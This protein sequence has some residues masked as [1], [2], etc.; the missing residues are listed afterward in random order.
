MA[1]KPNSPSPKRVCTESAG[2][3]PPYTCQPPDTLQPMYLIVPPPGMVQAHIAPENGSI[4]AAP[5]L[6]G[7]ISAASAPNQ[8]TDHFAPPN[9]T[10]PERNRRHRLWLQQELGLQTIWDHSS[11][12]P[13][14]VEHDNEG[15]L[16]RVMVLNSDTHPPIAVATCN[17]PQEVWNQMGQ[18]HQVRVQYS[19]TGFPTN[20]W[21]PWWAGAPRPDPDESPVPDPDYWSCCGPYASDPPW[22]ES[23]RLSDVALPA[24][25]HTAGSAP[26][27]EAD[28]SPLEAEAAPSAEGGDT[29]V[30]APPVE[31]L[32][33]YFSDNEWDGLMTG[34]LPDTGV[35][36]EILHDMGGTSASSAG[37]SAESAP[38]ENPQ[39]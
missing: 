5:E 30:S 37:P 39:R 25:V 22:A 11:G 23:P 31:G 36:H 14:F 16:A 28:T 12:H 2:S 33:K 34:T 32:R 15:N 27:V 38:L 19:D 17:G 1:E 18:E 35:L 8:D 26:E 3:A 24:I 6:D 4:Y 9:L 20:I 7:W 29:V 13:I 21:V 10:P